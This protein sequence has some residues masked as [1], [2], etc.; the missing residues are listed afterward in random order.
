MIKPS[1]NKIKIIISLVA[2][3]VL[4]TLLFTNTASFRNVSVSSNVGNG[5]RT[6]GS[7]TMDTPYQQFFVPAQQELSYIE[8]RFAT[9][10]D[11]TAKGTVQ[12]AL[13]DDAGKTLSTKTV[14]IKDLQDDAYYRFDTN[15]KLGASRTYSY[16]LSAIDVGWD[17]API[18]WPR[19]PRG[20]RE[21]RPRDAPFRTRGRETACGRA[22][23]TER[24]TPA[25]K[26]PA[27]GLPGRR[28]RD[29]GRGTPPRTTPRTTGRARP[30]S[31]L[32][33][34]CPRL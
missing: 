7:L 23:R 34:L 10:T 30:S 2:A 14:P 26:W 22:A 19:R 6:M 5:S 24:A 11:E 1:K 16:T 25:R 13:L 17:K 20:H 21:A 27:G 29:R 18:A 31:P 4:M 12:F 15:V 32:S 28:V 8:I 9:Y 3:I 33:E